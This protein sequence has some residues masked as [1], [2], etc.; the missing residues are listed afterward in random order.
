LHFF[1]FTFFDKK[2]KPKNIDFV[3]IIYPLGAIFAP[4]VH[5]LKK[6]NN[7]NVLKLYV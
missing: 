6:A 3:F 2:G 4:P 7:S 1:D 5:F